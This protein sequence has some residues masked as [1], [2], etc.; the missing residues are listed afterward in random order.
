VFRIRRVPYDSTAV[1]AEVIRQVQKILCGQFP[2][3]VE[4]EVQMLPEKLR[5]PFKYRFRSMLFVAEDAQERVRGFALLQ[6]A[7]DLN[8]CFLDFIAAAPG[9]AGGGVGGALYQRVREE[10]LALEVIGIFCE[11]LPDDPLLSRD[12]LIRRQNAERLRFY[13]RYGARPIANTA[14]ETPLKSGDD[15]PPYLVFDGLARLKL[16]SREQAQ[17]VVEAILRRK[18]ADL[19]PPA[20]IQRVVESFRDD[21]IVLRRPRY[22]RREVDAPVTAERYLA[23]RIPLVVNA[24]HDIHHV[25]ERGYVEAPVRI[26]TIL[27]ALDGTGL[28]ERAEPRHF[29]DRHLLAVHDSRLVDYLRRACRLVGTGRSAYP[30]VF[31]LR[32]AARPPREL[33]L[34][35]GYFC[36]DT[37]TPIN[38]NA[39]LAARRAVDCALTAAERVLEGQ[40]L[41][42]AL[43][44]PPGH[45]AERRAFGG[46][47]YFNNTAV[48]ANYLSRYG[49]VAVLDIDYHH[50]NGTQDIFYQR[51]DVLTIS[52]H[53]HPRFSYPYFSGFHEEQGEG[54]GTGCNLNIALPEAVS[55]AQYRDALARALARI[56]RFQ[57]SF[58]VVAAGFD[59]A[60][61]DPTGS[62]EH[63]AKDFHG[64]GRAIGA[65]GLPCV[66]VQEG[67][68]RI[69]VLGTNVKSFFE[70]LW[71]GARQSMTGQPRAGK[72]LP[73]AAAFPAVELI[74]W[75]QQVK[76]SDVDAVRGLVARTGVFSAQE[77]D[78]AAELVRERLQQGN[79]VGYHFLFAEH[80]DQLVGYTCFGPIPATDARFD[81]Y[82]IA[83]HP[84]RCR[85]RLGR[86]LLARTERA[87]TDLGGRQLYAETS[88]SDRYQ[89]ARR[90]YR[91]TG[92]R[93]VAR[94]PHFYREHDDKVI[95]QKTLILSVA[96]ELSRCTK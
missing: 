59:T 68:Y 56:S 77:V 76:A 31:P 5:N 32:N 8:F 82:W 88:G 47:C 23:A 15:N 58:L 66:V 14:Y 65:L 26:A 53:G 38:G 1:N 61:G 39:Y 33:P 21:P 22:V 60:A 57:P 62:W 73:P 94:L 17:T 52:L 89:A 83:V 74:R 48:A 42:Y 3:L 18:Y 86:E 50:G 64:I 55:P 24:Q 7:P 80:D 45:H 11:C 25:R 51:A 72:R 28:F 81:L 46:F 19:C 43:V 63:R 10:A 92:F 95:Y 79:A 4:S 36:I 49:R 34:R 75:R 87:V 91:S 20:Y 44:R 84:D 2:Q 27:K 40:R 71:Q 54:V 69:R 35:A 41:A 78:V 13:E 96:R 37:F 29:A 85:G 70:G 93:M 67:G 16:P 12:P 30:Y 6:H 9:R 90:F